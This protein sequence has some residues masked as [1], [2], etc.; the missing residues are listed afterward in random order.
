MTRGTRPYYVAVGN[1]ELVFKAAFRQ[2]GERGLKT[3]KCC[4]ALV[5]S[6]SVSRQG[7]MLD[8]R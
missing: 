5:E 4:G 2:G 1:E 7:K 8:P 3:G 6:N